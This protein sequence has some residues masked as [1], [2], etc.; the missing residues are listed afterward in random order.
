MIRNVTQNARLSSDL[1][2]GSANKPIWSYGYIIGTLE[3]LAF[4]YTRWV[5]GNESKALLLSSLIV[6]Y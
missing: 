3:V 1:L 2:I 5:S 4:Q 6:Q